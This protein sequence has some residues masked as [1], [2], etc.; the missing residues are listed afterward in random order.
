VQKISGDPDGEF[1]VFVTLPLLQAAA[2]VGVWARLGSF[3]ASQ[4]IGAVFFP[5]TG[6][7]VVVAFM[8]QDPRYPVIVGALYSKTRAPLYPPDEKNTM[9]AV[10][11]KSKLQLT[12]NDTDQIIQILTP[13]GHKI[14]LDDKAG[15]ISINDSNGNSAE[16]AAGGVTLDSASNIT[17]TAK[18]N[19]SVTAQGNLALKANA[20]ATMEGLQ[21]SHT[22]QTQF[23]AKANVQAS[24]TGSAMLTLKGGLVQIN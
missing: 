18:G 21:V 20:N 22:A 16:F 14:V 4:G 13:A 12:L 10:V 2:G 6:D 19:I 1:R 8:N 24:V 11:S 5:E 23:A 3:Y 15:S 9:K 7:E 17:L